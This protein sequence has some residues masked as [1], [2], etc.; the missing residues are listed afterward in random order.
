MS[1]TSIS[2]RMKN[3]NQEKYYSVGL[4]AFLKDNIKN[5]KLH[6]NCNF[7]KNIK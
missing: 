4:N 3:T 7:M 1:I 2:L 5:L 6:T